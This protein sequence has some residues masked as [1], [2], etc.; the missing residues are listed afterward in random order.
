MS[1][2]LIKSPCYFLPLPTASL[3]LPVVSEKRLPNLFACSVPP[4]SYCQGGDFQTDITKPES[5][6][7]TGIFSILVE[8]YCVD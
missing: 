7:R 6:K 8:N 1:A 3:V 5:Q 2:L 4:S